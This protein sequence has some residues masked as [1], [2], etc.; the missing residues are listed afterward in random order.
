MDIRRFPIFE[1]IIAEQCMIYSEHDLRLIDNDRDIPM[2]DKRLIKS[3]FQ[4]E[5]QR[6]QKI[7]Q[8][9]LN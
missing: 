7:R 2:R 3:L 5:M 8:K 9:F 4:N 1:L 6:L